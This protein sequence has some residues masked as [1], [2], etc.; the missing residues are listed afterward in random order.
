[1]ALLQRVP[2][3]LRPLGLTKRHVRLTGSQIR[4]FS[5]KLPFDDKEQAMEEMYVRVSAKRGWVGWVVV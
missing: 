5:D 1:M 3:I 4:A 2:L